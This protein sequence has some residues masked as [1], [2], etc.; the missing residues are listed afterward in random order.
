M[1]QNLAILLAVLA[2]GPYFSA[3]FSACSYFVRR[4]CN[5]TRFC[6]GTDPRQTPLARGSRQR[7]PP[8][9]PA[10]HLGA[11][12]AAICPVCD[13][14]EDLVLPQSFHAAKTRRIAIDISCALPPRVSDVP[15]GGDHSNSIARRVRVSPRAMPRIPARCLIVLAVEI[16]HCADARDRDSEWRRGSAALPESSLRAR[17]WIS[18]STRPGR[19][20]PKP[21]WRHGVAHP[22]RSM[23]RTSALHDRAVDRPDKSRPT[24]ALSNGRSGVGVRDGKCERGSH[25]HRFER[26]SDPARRSKR[27]HHPCCGWPAINSLSG[28]LACFLPACPDLSY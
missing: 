15:A 21:R 22:N 8:P 18:E 27:V 11:G 3:F 2:N 7:R 14:K 23:S 20:L 26:N 19:Q 4:C 17:S 6:S 28:P 10:G 1:H 16:Q 24:T 25:Y 13:P 12:D 5:N 9:P